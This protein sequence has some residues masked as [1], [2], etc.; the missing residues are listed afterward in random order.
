MDELWSGVAVVAAP[1]VEREHQL[2]HRGYT[3]VVFA[4]PM[5]VSAA[6]EAVVVPFSDR[7]SRRRFAAGALLV[8][9][10][11]LI[12]CAIA[13]SPWLFS[14]GLAVAGAASGAACSTAQAQ[15]LVV[16]DGAAERAMMRWTLFAAI[17]DVLAPLGVATVLAIGWSFRVALVAIAL[18]CLIQAL[19][20]ARDRRGVAPP[21]ADDEAAANPPRTR[22]LSRPWL[23]GWLF[24][25]AICTLLD[26][27]VAA[28]TSLRIRQDLGGTEA[29]ASA[30]LTTLSLGSVLGAFATDRVLERISPRRLMMGSAV[31]AGASLAVVAWSHST[32]VM[33]LALIA[34][35][36]S[37]ALHYPLA[38]ARAY[39]AARESPGIVNAMAQ[40]FVVLDIGAP[41][42]AGALADGYGL[43]IA[44][45]SLLLQP[46][47]ILTLAA[48][49]RFERVAESSDSGRAQ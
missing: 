39:T 40:V 21:P 27:V 5:L 10:A 35:G 11:S 41:I 45:A 12:A 46:I 9:A 48:V 26:E 18:V 2:G 34:L 14:V 15:L 49:S 4:A 32:V 3:L 29:V 24:G 7:M 17:G 6:I 19:A 23:W 8:L 28:L 13:Q 47:V 37:A 31:V 44:L 20:V 33:A 43:S 38:K 25:T 22:I 30:A 36:A 42:A 1:S 16:Y